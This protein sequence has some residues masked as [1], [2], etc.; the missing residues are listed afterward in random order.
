[1]SQENVEFVRRA[2]A[3]EPGDIE[4]LIEVYHEQAE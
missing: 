3:L 1:V 2:Y 4:R